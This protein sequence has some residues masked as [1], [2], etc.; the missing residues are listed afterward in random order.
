[1]WVIYL[2]AILRKGQIKSLTE[3]TS[4]DFIA[5]GVVERDGVNYVAVPFEGQQLFARLC[6]EGE[7]GWGGKEVIIFCFHRPAFCFRTSVFQTLQVRS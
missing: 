6:R 4:D 7:R 2:N 5:V 3:R 1:M